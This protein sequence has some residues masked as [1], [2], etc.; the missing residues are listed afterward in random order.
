MDAYAHALL[1]ICRVLERL[2]GKDAPARSQVREPV[3]PVHRHEGD[4]AL[5]QRLGRCRLTRRRRR[6]PSQV[7]RRHVLRNQ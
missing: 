5:E 6:Y 3:H 4:W 1:H 7:E 2:L